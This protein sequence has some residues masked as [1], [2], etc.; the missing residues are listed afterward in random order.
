M[1]AQTREKWGAGAAVA[2]ARDGRGLAAQGA[3]LGADQTRHGAG[4]MS[5]KNY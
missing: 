5:V 4:D 3:A 1:Q 2:G